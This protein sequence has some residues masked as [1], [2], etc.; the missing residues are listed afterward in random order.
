MGHSKRTLVQM[1]AAPDSLRAAGISEALVARL[2][3]RTSFSRT[4]LLI[5]FLHD[6]AM[7][8]DERRRAIQVAVPAFDLGLAGH[9]VQR[10]LKLRDGLL[11]ARQ[12]L[13]SKV[14]S[15]LD[16]VASINCS[17]ASMLARRATRSRLLRPQSLELFLRAT[18]DLLLGRNHLVLL[19]EQIR[20][21]P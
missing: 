13:L 8:I 21:V 2:R 7:R 11:G 3:G 19:L 17:F 4:E 20:S 10:F 18:N 6:V 5:D 12:A 16:W 14:K 9:D 1:D 15:F